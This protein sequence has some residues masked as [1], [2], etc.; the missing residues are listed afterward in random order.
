MIKTLLYPALLLIVF[1]VSCNNQ[2]NNDQ[3]PI[4]NEETQLKTQADKFPDS[5]LLRENLIQYYR[6]N[7]N[8][9]KA[10]EITD[11][12]LEKDSLNA[13][14]WDIK[15]TLY[16]ETADT[17]NAIKSFEKAVSLNPEPGY[18]M[19]LG[20]L[21]AQTKNPLALTMA[22]ALVKNPKSDE[23]KQSLFIKGLYYSSTGDN[24]KAI[25][26]FDT[27]ISTDYTFTF[28]YREKAI[29][30]YN[31]GKYNNALD[32]LS[33]ALAV[34]NTYDEAYYWMGRCNEKLGNKDEAVKNYQA[35]LQI[36]K[37]YIEAKNAL[38]RLGAQ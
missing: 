21:Y 18:I 19:T 5:L 27:C 6:D 15:G 10:Q 12:A 36:D 9:N 26:Y 8:Y 24:T 29:C 16:F 32:V 17:F 31:M 4:Q 30:L 13:R 22:D 3:P 38:T 33:K 25:A 20:S 34:E 23:Q 37:N 11:S 1:I 14:L 2:A 35:A 7:S 28:A